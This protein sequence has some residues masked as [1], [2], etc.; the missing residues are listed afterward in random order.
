MEIE[1]IV[2]DLDGTLLSMDST[3]MW[4]KKQLKSSPIRFVSAVAIMPVAIPLMKIKKYKSIGASL[5]VWVATYGLDEDKL[6]ENFKDFAMEVKSNPINK[7]HWFDEGIAEIKSHLENKRK[8]ILATAAPELLA[9]V[10]IRSINLDTE[11]EVIGTPLRRKLGGWIGGVH[12]RHKE[13]VRRLKLIGVSPKWLATYTDD[14]EEDYPI[15]INART[16]YLV[17]HNKNN[18]HTLENVKILEWH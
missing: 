11:I 3:K 14:I 17:N 10:L 12:C 4:L 8:V 2:F 1:N 16:Q 9:K 18:N 7:I 6:Q 13:K 15:L 5:F